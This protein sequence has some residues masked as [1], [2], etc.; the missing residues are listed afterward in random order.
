MTV[1]MSERRHELITN[2]CIYKSCRQ[3]KDGSITLYV[4]SGQQLK[5]L[6]NLCPNIRTISLE[7][8]IFDTNVWQDFRQLSFKCPSLGSVKHSGIG[9]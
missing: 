3:I 2:Y 5:F 9:R 8:T 1:K 7:F 4:L 6:F